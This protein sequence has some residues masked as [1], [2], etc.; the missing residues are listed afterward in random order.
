MGNTLSYNTVYPNQTTW[1]KVECISNLD[2]SCKSE[3]IIKLTYQ[4]LC[5]GTPTTVNSCSLGTFDLYSQLTGYTTGGTWSQISGTSVTI[6]SGSVTIT[7]YG[8]YVFRYTVGVSGQCQTHTDVNLNV[9]PAVNA[10]IAVPT[11]VCN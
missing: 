2:P 7:Q 6:T 9:L 11:T 5:A 1:Y 10:G 4:A 8:N 3:D